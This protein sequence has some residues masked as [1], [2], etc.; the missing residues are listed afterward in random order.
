M[1]VSVEPK[2]SSNTVPNRRSI[3]LANSA[4]SGAVAETT[5][6]SSG[7]STPDSSKARR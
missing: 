7:S 5:A 6:P 1:H 2:Y 4:G 3:A